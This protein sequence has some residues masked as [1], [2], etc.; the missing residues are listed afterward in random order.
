[1]ELM[2]KA[3]L[4]GLEGILRIAWKHKRKE[5]RR[6]SQCAKAMALDI[7]QLCCVIT[8]I[9]IIINSKNNIDNNYLLSL[10]RRA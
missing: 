10:Q 4:L 3:F 5:K 6:R 8:H 2:Q 7:L 1:M 9:E